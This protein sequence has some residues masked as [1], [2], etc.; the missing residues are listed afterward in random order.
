MIESRHRLSCWTD[1]AGHLNYG[2]RAPL[3]LRRKGGTQFIIVQSK[4]GHPAGEK[5]GKII[6]HG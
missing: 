4:G 1:A 5:D 2:K 3:R 6:E